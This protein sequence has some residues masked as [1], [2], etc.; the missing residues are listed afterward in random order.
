MTEWKWIVL[1]GGFTGDGSSKHRLY[2]NEDGD[3]VLVFNSHAAAEEHVLLHKLG[4]HAMIAEVVVEASPATE[5]NY[6]S[7]A[8]L[9]AGHPRS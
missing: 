3:R 6:K 1:S 4:E 5:L 8:R 2:R 7:G 9:M